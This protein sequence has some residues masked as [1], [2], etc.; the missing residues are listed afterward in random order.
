[1]KVRRALLDVRQVTNSADQ[2]IIPPVSQFL[3]GNA[4]ESA[5]SAVNCGKIES[6]A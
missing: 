1:M 3:S 6:F 5:A 4:R 2:F